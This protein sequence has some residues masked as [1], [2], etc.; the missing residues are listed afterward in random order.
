MKRPSMRAC[1][2]LVL[3]AVAAGLSVGGGAQV[4][5][6]T[7][8]D[9]VRVCGDGEAIL[10]S[11]QYSLIKQQRALKADPDNAANMHKVGVD[12]IQLCASV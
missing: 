6:Y 7:A 3:A 9:V 2:A 4:L 5:H 11:M 1:I 10:H 8:A 12:V